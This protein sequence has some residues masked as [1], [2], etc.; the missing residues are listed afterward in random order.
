MTLLHAAIAASP[1]PD[2]QRWALTV[3]LAAAIG[4]VALLEV[5]AGRRPSRTLLKP[6]PVAPPRA[7]PAVTPVRDL[8]RRR[9]ESIFPFE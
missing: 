9:H 6:P 5:V 1:Q 4:A 2:L 7:S 8:E 3:A